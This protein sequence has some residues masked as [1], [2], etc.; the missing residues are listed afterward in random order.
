AGR[1]R[2]R[3]SPVSWRNRIPD[4]R[5]VAGSPKKQKQKNGRADPLPF[6]NSKIVLLAAVDGL[7]QFCAG[8]ELCHATGSDLDGGAGLRVPAVARFALRNGKGSKADEG[9]AVAFLQCAGDA[10]HGRV[11]CAGS[12]G[13]ADAASRSNTIDKICFIHGSSWGVVIFLSGQ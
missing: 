2:R 7:F 12:L 1:I 8:G 13:L 9:D 4:S 3:L 5:L 6:C 11:D 10:L